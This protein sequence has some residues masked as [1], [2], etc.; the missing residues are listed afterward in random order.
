MT[1][2]QYEARVADFN[3]RAAAHS[4]RVDQFNA[5]GGV[6]PPDVHNRELAYLKRVD[7]ELDQEQ[8]ELNAE[9]ARI[10][11]QQH[12]PAPQTTVRP[13]TLPDAELT[14]R[15]KLGL[16]GCGLMF[17]GVV[18]AGMGFQLGAAVAI[19]GFILLLVWM[20]MWFIGVKGW[21]QEK[22]SSARLP[23]DAERAAAELAAIEWE[24]AERSAE[25]DRQKASRDAELDRL[26]RAAAVQ[27]AAESDDGWGDDD[28]DDD[29]EWV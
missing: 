13:S 7:A 25:L 6:L 4:A 8:A 5:H 3:A 14:T 23:N 1:L 9:H 27:A 28:D 21:G 19:F 10:A 15:A 29:D 20:W 11:A 22:I 16:W 24:N 2:E 26:R 17:V 18:I 12:V